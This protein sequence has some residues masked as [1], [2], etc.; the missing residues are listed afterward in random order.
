MLLES[1]RAISSSDAPV[2]AQ[3]VQTG[4]APAAATAAAAVPFGSDSFDVV[5]YG[6]GRFAEYAP[7]HSSAGA[8]LTPALV[9]ASIR[10]SSRSAQLQ[11][12]CILAVA[13]EQ[14]GVRLSGPVDAP[15]APS[16]MH[17]LPA[18]SDSSSATSAVASEPA[19]AATAASAA[20]RVFMYDPMLS[21]LE[22]AVGEALGVSIIP[23]NEEGE[24]NRQ[25]RVTATAT[26]AIRFAQSFAFVWCR[27]I[28]CLV[29][30]AP[31]KREVSRPTLFYM[32]HCPQVRVGDDC[33]Q[34]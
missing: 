34:R 26:A 23:D 30:T 4:A 28:S 13:Q 5:V 6:I 18:V 29:W 20:A 19:P 11:L 17:A 2:D 14:C 1:R 9:R 24:T 32:P 25:H 7:A 8:P 33:R 15:T 22:K 10:S 27:V 21:E 31:G 16:S 3:E 12:A